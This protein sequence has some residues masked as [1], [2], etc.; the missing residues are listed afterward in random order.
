M[1]LAYFDGDADLSSPERTRSGV[2]DATGVAHLLGIADTPLARIGRQVPML[3]E[4]QLTLLGYDTGDPDS[5]EAAAFA[6][7]PGLRHASD[8]QL[9]ADPAGVARAAVEAVSSPKAR[10]AVHFDV[11][12]VDSRDL[13]LANF[14][15]YGTG[16]PLAMAGQVLGTLL[17]APGLA[18]LTLT[19]VNPTHDP[20]GQLIER[21]IDTVVSALSSA[22]AA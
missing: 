22:L 7:R 19:E 5:Y 1:R 6:A 13:A 20:T 12:S 9:R 16:V 3:A 4:H 11:D 21:Y 10:V 2:L 15:H 18:S 17:A 14:P 8:A